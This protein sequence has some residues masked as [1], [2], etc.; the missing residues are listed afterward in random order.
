MQLIIEFEVFVQIISTNTDSNLPGTY[1][2]RSVVGLYD[3]I[4]IKKYISY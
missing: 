1:I 3:V 2:F 4:D